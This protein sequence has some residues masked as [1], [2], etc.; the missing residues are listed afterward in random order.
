MSAGEAMLVSELFYQK[1]NHMYIKNKEDNQ[2]SNNNIKTN[3]ENNLPS[4][5]KTIIE[6]ETR[7]LIDHQL[8]HTS[9]N[10]FY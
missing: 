10:L 6:K 2:Q 1:I 8:N 4:E 3:E 7:K 5:I 9:G